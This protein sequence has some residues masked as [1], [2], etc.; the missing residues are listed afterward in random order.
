MQYL[1]SV[2]ADPATTAE[3]AAYIE[4][5]FDRVLTEGEVSFPLQ[6]EPHV[7]AWRHYADEATQ[8]G[9]FPALQK[10]L[11]QLRFP[12]YA[13]ISQCSAYRAATRRGIP[14][15][16]MLEATGLE[17]SK[18]GELQLLIHDSFAG[19]IPVL[20]AAVRE[21]FV[22]LI[23]ALTARNEPVSIPASM[24]AMMVAGFNNWDRIRQI[25]EQ[26]HAVHLDDPSSDGWEQEFRENV[27]PD[28]TLY[29]DK[30]IILSDGPYSGV[31]ADGLGSFRH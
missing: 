25:K 12:I 15:E 21:D 23:Q 31:A 26:W 16:G 19:P 20:V 8:I 10:R 4:R 9:A 17:L 1:N 5:Q 29:Q 27:V 3:L 13:G 22:A 30:F 28:K 7:A 24:G 11:V 6:P 14:T 18:P 2:G